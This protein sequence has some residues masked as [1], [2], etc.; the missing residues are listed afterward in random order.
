MDDR[1]AA[2]R[3]RRAFRSRRTPRFPWREGNEFELLIDGPRFVPAVLE[4]IHQAR[5]DV[6]I[7]M[8][9]IASG[10]A[11][12]QRIDALLAARARDV[13]VRLLLDDFGV[14]ELNRVD[15][16]R[17]ID[18]GVSIV[19]FNPLRYGKWWRSLLRN[20]RKLLLVDG[21]QAF[22]GGAGITD[23]FAD[24]RWHETLVRIQGPCVADWYTVFERSWRRWAPRASAACSWSSDAGAAGGRRGRVSVSG[25]W[26]S[27][28]LQRDFIERIHISEHCIWM[29][30]A[31]FVPSWKL[32]HALRY[33]ARKGLDVRLLLPGPVT[34]HPGVRHAGRRF[35]KHL[36]RAGVRVFE[37]QPR[38][39]HS[40][41]MLCDDWVSLGSSNMDRWNL[42][43]NLEGNQEVIDGVFVEQVR[44]MFETDFR[45]AEE[46]TLQD[47]L[48]RPWRQRVL[49]WCWGRVDFWL[50]EIGRRL[51]QKIREKGKDKR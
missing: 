11:V 6:L 20:H 40:K 29:A 41:V 43:W 4:A 16:Q 45:D 9:L 7:E 21:K 23:E 44:A 46:V 33:G 22:V 50:D 49:E 27:G 14:L 32:R 1:V 47:W 13:D 15:R 35:Y 31:Y 48:K 38:F 10:A 26:G 17:L 5:R 39:L 24:G 19:Y 25:Q 2:Q 18:G 37:Y 30:T 28:T 8:Y 36:L 42:R 51:W 3:D 34:D 12:T